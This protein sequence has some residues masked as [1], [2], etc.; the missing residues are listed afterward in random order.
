MYHAPYACDKEFGVVEDIATFSVHLD[1]CSCC[2]FQDGGLAAEHKP[3]KAQIKGKSCM[4]FTRMV[5]D[6]NLGVVDISTPSANVCKCTMLHMLMT[7]NSG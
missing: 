1:I 4:M 2:V 3:H 7:R 6:V 5:F